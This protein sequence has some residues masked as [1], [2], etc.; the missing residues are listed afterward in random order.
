MSLRD[1][2]VQKILLTAAVTVTVL[3]GFFVSDLL[4]FGYSR[5][6]KET[7]KLRAEY[8]S[9]STELEKAR[10]TVGNLPQLER[11]HAELQKRW[12][13]AEAL[14][15]TDKEVAQLLTQVT[16]AG[17]QAGVTFELFKP[18][19]PKPQEFYNENPVAVQVACGFHQLGIFLSRLA[20][21]PRLVNVSGLQLSGVSG[22]ELEKRRESG[23]LGR[24]DH[25]LTASFTATAYSL[26]DPVAQP[27]QAP[28]AE[29][30]GRRIPRRI[31]QRQTRGGASGVQEH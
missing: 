28:P 12:K 8:E 14:L 7:A 21:L 2:R 20:N 27:E 26:R 29:K 13:Q 18:E 15:P 16:R 31:P 6:A 24:T 9:V 11:E 3:W 19:A 23:A 17:E 25:T 5:R 4:P 1:P 10:R 30:S 22:R